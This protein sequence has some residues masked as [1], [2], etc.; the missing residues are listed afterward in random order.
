M[1]CRRLAIVLVLC[2]SGPVA[3]QVLGPAHLREGDAVR[4]NSVSPEGAPAVL[5]VFN[6]LHEARKYGRDLAAAN[7]ADRLLKVEGITYIGHNSPATIRRTQSGR[8]DDGTSYNLALIRI[9]GGVLD[10]RE[11]WTSVKRLRPADEPDPA[12]ERIEPPRVAGRKRATQ[13]PANGPAPIAGDLVL[14]DVASNPSATG[15]YVE[16]AGR[17]RN[18]S[19]KA[20]R[21]V[22]VTVSFEDRSGKLVRSESAYCEPQTIEPGGLASF[23]LNAPERRSLCRIQ[24]VLPGH[25]SGNSLGQP[26]GEG[27]ARVTR[28]EWLLALAAQSNQGSGADSGFWL[29]TRS[30]SRMVTMGETMAKK[31]MGR[32]KTSLRGDVSIKFDKILARKAKAISDARGISRAQYLSELARPMIDKDYAKLMRELEGGGQ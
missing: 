7:K 21:F 26:L 4:V 1:L 8:E 25:G 20:L 30:R 22:K 23:E 16:V 27:C 18:T 28:A 12:V 29:L 5:P 13:R 11:L 19:G 10:G 17:V 14:I 6:L 24:A 15:N 32:P 9:E 2:T 31:Q 3:A